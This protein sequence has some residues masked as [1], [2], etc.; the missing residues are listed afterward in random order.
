[1]ARLLEP[2]ERI[3]GIFAQIAICATNA[4]IDIVI[5]PPP[6]LGDDVIA[7]WGFY[8]TLAVWTGFPF[9]LGEGVPGGR[10]A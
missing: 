10:L 8:I 9:I 5:N 1:M 4:V 6:L 7:V 3:F 2:D